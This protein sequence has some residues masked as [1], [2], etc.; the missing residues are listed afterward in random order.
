[1]ASLGGAWRRHLS[2]Y[3]GDW[4]W[5]VLLGFVI[6]AVAATVAILASRDHHESAATTLIATTAEPPTTASTQGVPS[7]P[8]APSTAA[9]TPAP[10]TKAT[11]AATPRRQPK[12]RPANALTSWPAGK[13]GYTIVLESLPASGGLKAAQAKAREALGAGLRRVGVIDSSQ[14]SSLH[15]GYYVIFAGIYGSNAQAQA[16]VARAHARYAGAYVRQIVS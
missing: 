10:A 4:I 3:P 8:T 14:Y 5:P 11:P 12:P 2:W 1:V 15:P 16:D 7:E 9:A 13:S 6:A